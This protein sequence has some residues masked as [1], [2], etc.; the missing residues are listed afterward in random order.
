MVPGYLAD[1]YHDGGQAVAAHGTGNAPQAMALH[2]QI[3]LWLLR[4]QLALEP[5]SDAQQRIF[6]GFSGGATQDPPRRYMPVGKHLF[7][8]A[9]MPLNAFNGYSRLL[10]VSYHAVGDGRPDYRSAAAA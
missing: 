1:V 10:L 7:A 6:A 8:P 3:L 2:D 4:D 9:G 5:M